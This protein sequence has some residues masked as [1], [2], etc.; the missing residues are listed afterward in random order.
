MELVRGIEQLVNKAKENT[1]AYVRSEEEEKKEKA[2]AA[3]VPASAGERK[4][5]MEELKKEYL[6]K[7]DLLKELNY[8]VETERAFVQAYARLVGARYAALFKQGK[9]DY[10]SGRGG[11]CADAGG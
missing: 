11:D 6:G 1:K 2:K 5:K 4:K 10:D 8:P 3:V 7:V 9:A